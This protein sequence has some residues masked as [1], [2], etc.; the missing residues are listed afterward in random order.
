LHQLFGQKYKLIA[1][2]QRDDNKRQIA[3]TKWLEEEQEMKRMLQKAAEVAYLEGLIDVDTKK[4]YH[5]SSECVFIPL[6]KIFFK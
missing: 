6:I 4:K 5:M 2:L 3:R 1:L